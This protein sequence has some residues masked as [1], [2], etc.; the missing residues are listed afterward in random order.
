[1]KLGINDLLDKIREESHGNKVYSAHDHEARI[2]EETARQGKQYD[3]DFKAATKTLKNEPSLKADEEW[4]PEPEIMDRAAHLMA[5]DDNLE[6]YQ[7]YQDA[8][9]ERARD[10]I[11]EN[12]QIEELHRAR[13]DETGEIPGWDQSAAEPWLHGRPEHVPD[14]RE[15]SA[16]VGPV[17][18]GGEERANGPATEA[19]L[20]QRGEP[21]FEPGAERKPQQL[22]PGVAPVS[23]RER[24][25]LAAGK[26]LTGGNAPPPEGGLFDE[27]ARNQ[28]ELFQRQ[29]QEAPTFYSAVGRAIETA[30]QEKASPQQ[31]LA[32]LRN[33]AG[34]KPEEMKWLGL[35]DWLKEQN[36]AVTRAQIADYVRANSIEVKE[37]EKGKTAER[38]LDEQER[39]GH[40]LGLAIDRLG[41]SI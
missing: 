20:A 11:E 27:N 14:L 7:A 15:E 41:Q 40:D 36:G 32:T 8:L 12:D 18:T 31:W 21:A 6:P 10:L 35:E 30:K 28:Q 13:I 24:A 26:P 17:G 39:L 25:E 9:F 33:T 19:V 29:E 5:Q 38:E 1:M 4:A 22:I 23:D 3:K 2:A 37:V 16:G 34:V